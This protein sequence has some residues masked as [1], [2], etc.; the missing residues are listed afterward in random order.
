[1]QLYNIYSLCRSLLNTNQLV[2]LPFNFKV[3]KHYDVL[4]YKRSSQIKLRPRKTIKIIAD[5]LN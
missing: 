5:K 3:K 4:L 1:M 2:L